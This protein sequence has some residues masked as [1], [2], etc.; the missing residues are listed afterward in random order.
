MD[1]AATTQLEPEVLT[2]MLPFLTTHFGNP[3]SRH[4][5]GLQ[6][7][8]AIERSRETIAEAINVDPKCICFTSGATEAN[9]LALNYYRSSEVSMADEVW[10]SA[11][12]HESILATCEALPIVKHKELPVDENGQ[13]VLDRHFGDAHSS[14][15][16]KELGN[17]MLCVMGANNEVGTLQPLDQIAEFANESRMKYHCDAVQLFPHR[18]V[19][20]SRCSSMSLSAHK[21]GGPK[22]VGLL[23]ANY[24]VVVPLMHGG[25][26]EQNKR[27]GTE[28]VAG[29]VG[30][31]KAVELLELHREEYEAKAIE[32]QKLF[33]E[34]LMNSIDGVHINGNPDMGVGGIVNVSFDGAGG[35]II[36]M[37]LDAD[38]ICVSNGSAC[39]SNKLKSSH[40]LSAMGI[41]AE[42][43]TN[44]IR[45]SMNHHNTPEEVDEVVSVLKNAVKF[46]RNLSGRS[47]DDMQ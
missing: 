31:A 16:P 47:A 13:I 41:P 42:R 10:Y 32:L 27:S 43:A 25:G 11:I 20:A 3:S 40:V 45:F 46:A 39:A 23:Y 14:F 15:I 6:A 28:N 29:I 37:R 1:N 21:F 4:A 24:P 35:E 33:I 18:K 9:N 30:M 7:R 8:T 2:A 22:G 38:G 34:R 5:L 17:R 12:E 19:D 36:L 44:A 26:Q